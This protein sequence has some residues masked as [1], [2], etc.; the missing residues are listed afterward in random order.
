MWT[1]IARKMTN[2]TYLAE[3]ALRRVLNRMTDA[4]FEHLSPFLRNPRWEATN[5]GAER[6]GRAFRHG[7]AAHFNLRAKRPSRAVWSWTSA[8]A[9]QPHT[10]PQSSIPVA[11]PVAASDEIQCSST[12]HQQTSIAQSRKHVDQ[13]SPKDDTQPANSPGKPRD[14]PAKMD[15]ERAL[16]GLPRLCVAQTM[17]SWY[18]ARV[19]GAH[20][21]S[22]EGSPVRVAAPG[23]PGHPGRNCGGLRAGGRRHRERQPGRGAR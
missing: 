10:M 17:Y 12:V 7:Q 11:L 8:S 22:D 5:N 14:P 9:R 23:S 4:R 16:A 21:N 13:Y 19:E 2:P 6:A 18:N 3:P 15:F 1:S 20:R